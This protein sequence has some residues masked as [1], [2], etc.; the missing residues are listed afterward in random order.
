MAGGAERTIQLINIAAAMRLL[1][2]ER[3]AQLSAGT[4]RLM[5]K[6]LQRAA[7]LPA[8]FARWTADRALVDE[9]FLSPGYQRALANHKPHLPRLASAD[10]AVVEELERRGVHVT[11]LDALAL[12]GSAE[13][14]SAAQKVMT[15]LKANSRQSR[16]Q[17]RHTVVATAG[18][19]SLYPE[20]FIWGLHARLLG[21]AES[22]LK[23]PPAYD[24]FSAYYSIADGR[25]AGPR[26]WHRDREDRRM[27][28]VGVYF[29][30]VDDSGGP[31]Q[32][33]RPL[34]NEMVL[35]ATEHR[36]KVL[37]H[38]QVRTIIGRSNDD[39]LETCRGESGTVIFAD[40]ASYFHRGK[41]P[42]AAERAAIYFGYFSR[43]P[44]HSFL[45]ER[46][47]FTRGQIKRMVAA[48]PKQ[49]QHC[50]CWPEALPLWRR[51]IPKNRI[52]V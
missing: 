4:E 41:P 15:L 26:L 49:Q 34:D 30:D 14:V 7:S 22:Y 46:S 39:W 47:P 25:E 40:T 36:Y 19:L 33:I 42:T 44:L 37:S 3:A 24:G 9:I 5:E 52:K 45:C 18:H 50:A 43:T 8:E 12:P 48:L 11:S 23:L 2:S 16:Y 6:G 32:I 10:S 31:F 38:Q 28:K 1:V 13:L 21:I 17:G 35:Q 20:I 27:L 51:L 29:N